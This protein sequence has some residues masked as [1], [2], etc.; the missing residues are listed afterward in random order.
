[1]S[2]PGK[3]VLGLVGTLIVLV[4]IAV[5]LVLLNINS[6]IKYAVEQYG[7]SVTG[8]P[9]NLN[10]VDVALL[11]GKAELHGLEIGNPEGFD[12]DYAFK[13]DDVKMHLIPESVTSDT[14]LIEQI[15]IGEANLN[16]EF[17]GTS[18]NLQQILDNVKKS[19]EPATQPE[20]ST[21]EEQPAAEA[22]PGEAKKFI[23]KEF[24]FI[25]GTVTVS[26][27]LAKMQRT[28]EIPAV[29]IHD[30][31]NASG[32]V[33]AAELTEQLLR[34]V[35]EKALQ[36]AQAE[37]LEQGTE[38]MKKKAQEKLQDKLKNLMQ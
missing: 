17:K 8:T 36:K 32:G 11:S 37:A 10:K 14:I 4:I 24:R 35:I 6:S 16:A 21:Q 2:R 18:S 15:L 22:E 3:I 28:A 13:L 38:Q 27:D 34:P 26:S 5:G 23:V 31:G 7:P 1:M 29:E 30:I 12:S 9:V 25:G 20:P 33:T 19:S